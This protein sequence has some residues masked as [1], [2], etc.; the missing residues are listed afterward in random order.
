MI[1]GTVYFPVNIMI[2]FIGLCNIICAASGFNSNCLFICPSVSISFCFCVEEF[3]KSILG[4]FSFYIKFLF[5]WIF[6]TMSCFIKLGLKN[7][8]FGCTFFRVRQ[9]RFVYMSCTQPVSCTWIT[10][11]CTRVRRSCMPPCT[12]NWTLKLKRFL[13][14]PSA[15]LDERNVWKTLTLKRSRF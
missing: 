11:A 1:K 13:A 8:K 6:Y 10:C 5:L 9:Y 14:F 12:W 2:S 4:R 7:W 3:H 15:W